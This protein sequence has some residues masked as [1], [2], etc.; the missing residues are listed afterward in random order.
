MIQEAVAVKLALSEQLE[1][2][3]H[4]ASGLEVASEASQ[5]MQQE[6]EATVAG[7]SLY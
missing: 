3:R 2:A 7:S 6:L 4:M 5:Q 1:A